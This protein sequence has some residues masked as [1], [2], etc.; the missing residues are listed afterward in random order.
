M[1]L[2]KPDK[3]LLKYQDPRNTNHDQGS[4]HTDHGNENSHTEVSNKDNENHG[5]KAQLTNLKRSKRRSAVR[6]A[7]P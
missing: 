7:L 1:N 4:N 3:S 5:N 6:Y 2:P